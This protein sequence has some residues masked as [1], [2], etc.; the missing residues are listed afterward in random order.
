MTDIIST[1][2]I[3]PPEGR[4]VDVHDVCVWLLRVLD[5]KSKSVAFTAS[6]FSFYLK[7]GGIT[8]KQQAALLKIY[9]KTVDQYERNALICQGMIAGDDG[10]EANV[11]SLSTR[12]AKSK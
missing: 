5:R 4:S 8:E 12:R 11:V 10:S 1:I 6:V 2:S 9:D 3:E 7:Q